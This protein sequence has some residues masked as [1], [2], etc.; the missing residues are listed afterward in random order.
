MDSNSDNDSLAGADDTG[1]F[2]EFDDTD[3]V[4]VIGM[5]KRV[6]KVDDAI[7]TEAYEERK[8][9]SDSVR[10]SCCQK[11][12]KENDDSVCQPMLE[13]AVKGFTAERLLN[14][15]VGEDTRDE[16]VCNRVPRG[17]RHH[18]AFVVDT[19]S[20]E[21]D[22]VSYGDDNGSWTGHSKPRRKYH[23]EVDDDTGMLT[24]EEYQSELGD[25]QDLDNNIYTLCCIYFR[26][27]HTPSLER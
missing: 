19:T 8:M 9:T 13:R 12:E 5:H 16:K 7:K 24:V 11:S 1:T 3:K 26:H 10:R 6:S 23:I 21:A 27:A 22:I 4:S 20:F 2:S 25:I 14:I 17:V 18:A 15:I